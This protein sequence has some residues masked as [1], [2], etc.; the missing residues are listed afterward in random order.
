MRAIVFAS[1]TTLAFSAALLVACGGGSNA[2][3]AKAAGAPGSTDPAATTAAAGGDPSA[4]TGTANPAAGDAGPTTTTTMNL[5]KAGDLQGAKLTSTSSTTIQTKGDGGATPDPK[6]GG[7]P[8]RRREDFQALIVARRDEARKCYDD[9]L[10]AHPGM[11][12]NLDIKW[13]I[14]PKG[15]ISDIAVDDSKSEIHDE[16][17]GKCVINVI[18]QITFAASPKG[19]ESRTHYPFNFHPRG[20]QPPKN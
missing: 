12:G 7:D 5:N 4:A 13:T 18:K 8:G 10:K 6:S 19:F 9:G 1:V 14:D 2:P 3:G 15:V 16:A 11:E 17:V 20:P